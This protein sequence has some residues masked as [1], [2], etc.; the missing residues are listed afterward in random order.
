MIKETKID[1]A[2]YKADF[3]ISENYIK[4][5]SELLRLSL[6]A[7]AGYGTLFIKTIVEDDKNSLIRNN[8][9]L[10]LSM[11]FF[12]LSTSASLFHRYYATDSMSWFISWRRFLINNKIEKAELENIGMKKILKKSKIALIICEATFGCGVLIFL[13]A[14]FKMT[15]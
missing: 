11:I 15:L 4:F 1:E 14:I 8:S 13:V 7:I 12:V 5:S 9:I 2:E 6:L 10:I 3:T